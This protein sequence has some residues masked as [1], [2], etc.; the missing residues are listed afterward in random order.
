MPG[1][2]GNAS[3]PLCVSQMSWAT[4]PTRRQLGMDISMIFWKLFYMEVAKL[5]MRKMP[6]K[7]TDP[8]GKG[9][10]YT[11]TRK[12]RN[13]P[14]T[15]VSPEAEARKC[16]TEGKDIPQDDRFEIRF[17]DSVKGKGVFAAKKFKKGDYLMW[18]SG[19]RL[20][21]TEATE[22]ETLY[23]QTGAGSYMYFF[24]DTGKCMAIDA[25]NI[26]NVARY[27][28]DG[29]IKPNSVMKKV[30][31]ES[32]AVH[33]CLFAQRDIDLNEE[34]VYNYGRGLDLPWRKVHKDACQAS[35]QLSACVEN[36]SD[37][38]SR[39]GSDI[40]KKNSLGNPEPPAAKTRK[41]RCDIC[42]KTSTNEDEIKQCQKWHMTPASPVVSPH[43]PYPAT[44][45]RWSEKLSFL[46]NLK[47]LK[48]LNA[49]K[50]HKS[51]LIAAGSRGKVFLGLY[52]DLAV[53]IKRVESDAVLK[54]ELHIFRLLSEANVSAT[55]KNVLPQVHVEEDD[56]F[57]YFVTPL[58]EGNARDLI[59][60]RIPCKLPLTVNRRLSLCKD[61]LTGIN[62]LHQ[63]GIIH[64]DLKPENL[65]IDVDGTLKIADFGISKRLDLGKTTLATCVAGTCAWMASE[66][67]VAFFSGCNFMYKKSADVQDDLQ[68]LRDNIIKGCYNLGH[69]CEF[70]Q[71]MSGLILNM[72]AIDPLE[73]P[74][75]EE[76]IQTFL[77]I[78]AFYDHTV[79]SEVSLG[80]QGGMDSL[81]ADMSSKPIR[82]DTG[83]TSDAPHPTVKTKQCMPAVIPRVSAKR[84]TDIT[85]GMIP[86]QSNPVSLQLKSSVISDH[87]LSRAES[88][89]KSEPVAGTHEK[90][91]ASNS[92]FSIPKNI[93]LS[94]KSG[95]ESNSP[96]SFVK[97]HP[98]SNVPEGTVKPNPV[99]GGSESLVKSNLESSIPDGNGMQNPAPSIPES[100]VK[101]HPVSNVPE[102]TVMPNPVSGGSESLVKSNLESSIPDG[103]Y[104]P[105]PAPSIPESFVKSHP[106]SNVPEGTVKPNPVSGGS[107]SLAKSNLESSIPDGKYMPNPAPSIPESFVKSHPVSNVPEGTVM[108]SPVSGGSE[109][110]AKSN[111]ESS[112]PDGNG[113]RNPAPSIPESFV[114]SHPVSNVPEGTVMPSPVSGGSESLAKSNLESSIPDGN[115]MPNPAPSIPESFVKSHP[116]SNVPEGTVM[117]SPV[118]GG[119]ESLVKSNLESSIPDG[120]GMRNPAPSIPESFVKSHPVSNVPEGTVIPTLYLVGLKALSSQP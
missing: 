72:L 107:E 96:E 55:V 112:I 39:S 10:V 30:C 110:L 18:Y 88:S 75:S 106:V 26:E 47:N 36:M 52:Q 11:K 79:S 4:P 80:K 108:P 50:Y 43:G 34:I 89:A 99:S 61:F 5:Y 31:D 91:L 6:R 92:V 22:R 63:M 41:F 93:R 73:R 83:L 90:S 68:G 66:T 25:T 23:D 98:V 113:M 35:D 86:I 53:A 74:Q 102:G 8:L 19:E 67:C 94:V 114:K 20:S 12:R 85:T 14:S 81:A 84:V 101:S 105:N 95:P 70:P 60:G 28:N 97:S 58:C 115:V 7:Q 49:I 76:C 40:V 117:P 64:R 111:L 38:P 37:E 57:T 16:V 46:R 82:I 104:M 116:V 32:D 54:D 103:K 119:S 118:S 120:N 69:V 62:E 56:D 71:L 77:K 17:I 1:A 24:K 27:V 87:L 29:H 15:A 109:S 44:G 100:F 48:E 21:Q 2:R 33:L 78:Q 13:S 9:L 59:E 65:L 42:E 3:P 45:G 51:C